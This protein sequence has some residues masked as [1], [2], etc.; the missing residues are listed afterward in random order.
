MSVIH[1]RTIDEIRCASGQFLRKM[2]E[3]YDDMYKEFV[4]QP[5]PT[6]DNLSGT[7][8]ELW[9][10][11]RNKVLKSMEPGDISYAYHVAMGAQNYLDEMTDTR[12]TKKFDLMKYFDSDN[13]KLF[14][15]KFLQAMDDYL[16]EYN[17]VGKKVVQFDTFEQ[18]Y[19]YYMD[20]EV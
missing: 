7:Y 15:D 5:I 18:L 19:S 2:V 12:G 3:L 1:A 16:E 9:C 20:C 14:R 11:C 4:E 17:K 10:N 6:N 13:L 8:E